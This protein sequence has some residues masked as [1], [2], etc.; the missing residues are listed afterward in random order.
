M[1]IRKSQR[2]RDCADAHVRVTEQKIGPLHFL[3]QDILFQTHS[4]NS[5]KIL[6]KILFVVT[7]MTGNRGNPDIIRNEIIDI[8]Y[9]IAVKLLL[10]RLLLERLILFQQGIGTLICNLTENQRTHIIR[11]VRV[12]AGTDTIL[13]LTHQK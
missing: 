10:C 12:I 5:L 8:I 13:K 4:G 9:D 2:I 3:I 1:I 7:K 11:I 6:G